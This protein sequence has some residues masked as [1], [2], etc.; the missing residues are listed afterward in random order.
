MRGH[1]GKHDQG[2]DEKNRQEWG[3]AQAND[4]LTCSNPDH[5]PSAHTLLCSL[6]LHCCLH[7]KL[8]YSH[9]PEN[10]FPEYVC[11]RSGVAPPLIRYH[12]ISPPSCH[13][14]P[15]AILQGLCPFL[16][17]CSPS[18]DKEGGDITATVCLC[19]QVFFFFLVVV[20]FGFVC[21]SK[22]R[23][24]ET[25]TRQLG[26]MFTCQSLITAFTCWFIYNRL[27]ARFLMMLKLV[28]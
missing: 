24:C 3:K 11:V 18:K 28:I 25:K 20:F 7:P 9:T 27:K 16:A 15:M 17:L 5:L 13:L 8:L 10:G 14:L 19:W 21:Y 1:E 4:F 2:T 23:T 12:T 6:P 22:Y 26:D